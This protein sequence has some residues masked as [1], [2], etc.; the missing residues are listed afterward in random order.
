MTTTAEVQAPIAPYRPYDVRLADRRHVGDSFVRLTFT[1]PDLE[2]CGDV[3][4]DQR[5]K[6]VLGDD[7]ALD[8]LHGDEWYARWL[9]LPSIARPA[10]RTY[11][12][13][14]V[15][16]RLGEVDIDVVLHGAGH[17]LVTGPASHFAATAPLGSRVLLVAAD[18][19]SDEAQIAGVAFQPGQARQIVLVADETALPAVTNILAAYGD[20]RECHAI[21]EVPS[22]GDIRPLPGQV[23]WRVRAHGESA[24]DALPFPCRPTPGRTGDRGALTLA[25]PGQ[26]RRVRHDDLVWDEAPGSADA[27]YL[28]VAG[29][30]GLVRAVR[31]CAKAS[32]VS[33]GGAAFMGYWRNGAA[34]A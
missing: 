23:T 8:A 16:P 11:T 2:L 33:R 26:L 27:P 17:Q 18:R 3:M 14:A 1:G 9:A 13:A 12:L 31:A 10:L 34:S 28:W 7:A 32:G 4:L 30:A 25:A 24:L 5:V 6:L 19:R 20:R 21:V 15:R 29:E 22:A